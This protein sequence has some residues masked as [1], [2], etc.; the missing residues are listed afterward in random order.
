MKKIICCAAITSLLLGMGLSSVS[1]AD[2]TQEQLTERLQHVNRSAKTGGRMQTAFHAIATETGVPLEQIE[3]LYKRYPEEGPAGVLMACVMA[4]ETKK[5]PEEFVK[6]NM[7]GKSWTQLA[8]EYKV[9]IDKLNERLDHMD[10]ILNS[11]TD[12][13]EKKRQH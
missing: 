2:R 4:D 9:S 10:R 7:A 1:G 3:A 6:K 12:K 8:K 5:S 11:A 13:P